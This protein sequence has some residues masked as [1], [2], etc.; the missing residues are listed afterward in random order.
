MFK[1]I[2]GTSDE[3]KMNHLDA[4]MSMFEQVYMNDVRS[5]FSTD[6]AQAS[7]EKASEDYMTQYLNF[8]ERGL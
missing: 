3:Y 7:A 4:A 8:K 2:F 6:V 5:G 1:F